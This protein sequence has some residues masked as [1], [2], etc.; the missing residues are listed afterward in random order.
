MKNN[1]R[2]PSERCCL[3]LFAWHCLA[4]FPYVPK[5]LQTSFGRSW[6]PAT[7]HKTFG[8]LEI[9][10]GKTF[11]STYTDLHTVKLIQT[12]AKQLDFDRWITLAYLLH[13]FNTWIRFTPA[14]EQAQGKMNNKASNRSGQK[15]GRTK[16]QRKTKGKPKENQGKPGRTPGK[17]GRTPRKTKN[18]GRSPSLV[19]HTNKELLLVLVVVDPEGARLRAF[20]WRTSL[21]LCVHACVYNYIKL[22]IN[23]ISFFNQPSLRALKATERLLVEVKLEVAVMLLEVVVL[24]KWCPPSIR[25]RSPETTDV[26][27]PCLP[28]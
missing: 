5:N 28:R 2:G 6:Q 20:T 4:I 18:P 17:P 13:S 8:D 22:Y 23:D 9:F 15:D 25:A 14:F 11:K 7:V 16:N 21:S 19:C 12:K 3:M 26:K 24:P 10:H 1:I 27:P